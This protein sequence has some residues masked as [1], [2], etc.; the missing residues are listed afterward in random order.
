[1]LE[2][3]TRELG[4]QI[5][6]TRYLWR[7]FSLGLRYLFILLRPSCDRGVLTKFM[8]VFI[9]YLQVKWITGGLGNF[10]N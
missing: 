2:V 8:D 5:D 3:N 10:K 1:M 6:P 9:L 4:A 7:Q